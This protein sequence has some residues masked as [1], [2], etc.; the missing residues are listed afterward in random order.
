MIEVIQKVLSLPLHLRCLMR[1]ST[2]TAASKNSVRSLVAA[3]SFSYTLR[4]SK[5]KKAQHAGSFYKNQICTAFLQSVCTFHLSH[6]S[7]IRNGVKEFVVYNNYRVIFHATLRDQIRKSGD[8]T[9]NFVESELH[10]EWEGTTELNFWLVT[11]D[12]DW[13]TVILVI[14]G[15]SGSFRNGGVDTTAKTLVRG[16]H[17]EEL[18]GVGLSDE[19]WVKTSVLKKKEAMS[20]RNHQTLNRKLWRE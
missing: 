13:S 11:D 18:V 20:I 6:S 15:A 7:L 2:R 1:S 4:G 9:I 12:H 16:D 17:N 10:V 19:T 8:I 3:S 5:K 14:D